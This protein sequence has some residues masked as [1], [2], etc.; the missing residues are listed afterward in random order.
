MKPET[1]MPGKRIVYFGGMW[2][3]SKFESQAGEIARSIDD[4]DEPA[5]RKF[6]F[7]NSSAWLRRSMPAKSR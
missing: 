4:G 5:A 7:M 1:E 2:C 3:F 6:S